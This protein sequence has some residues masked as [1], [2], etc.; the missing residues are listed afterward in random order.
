MLQG[1]VVVSMLRLNISYAVARVCRF[2]LASRSCMLACRVDAE[3]VMFIACV[4]SKNDMSH[5]HT[6]DSTHV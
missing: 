1:I 6:L 2:V 3:L 5:K 4:H